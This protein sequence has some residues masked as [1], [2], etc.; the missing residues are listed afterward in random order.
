M[1][2]AMS[3]TD[4]Y[5]HAFESL[6]K[7]FD[8]GAPLWLH[9]TRE[10]AISR[11]RELGFPTTKAE[12]WKYTNVAP[13]TKVP[14]QPVP[15]AEPH[16]VAG[17]AVD[18]YT[19]GVLKCS[20]LVFING[21]FAP[22][23]SY[24]RW[25]PE[26]VRVRSLSEVLEKDARSLE[27]HLGRVAALDGNPFTALNT[28]FMQEGAFIHVPSGRV[29]E[30]PIHLLFVSASRK[31]PAVSY[32]RNLVVLAENSQA[33][34]I[35]SYAGLDRG[36]Y[37]TNA[38]TEVVVGPGAV[39][40][41]YK[42]Q[43]ESESAFH[44]A[45]MAVHQDRSS[46]VACNSISL[47]GALARNDV[48]AIFKGEGGELDLNGLYAVAGQ[49]HVDNHTWIDHARPNCTSRELYKGILD[50]KSRGIFNA[51]IFVRKEGQ[52]TN[53]R[54]TNKNLLLSNDAFVDSTPGLEILADDV[55][56]S[57]GS[58]IGQLDENAIFYLRS[59]GIDEEAARSLL[60]YAFASELINQVKVASMR[61][62]LDQLIL[63]RLPRADTVKEAV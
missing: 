33:T 63:S 52:K 35:E 45:T 14:F 5:V 61:I 42:M 22:R 7:D 1:A 36:L 49:Q 47:G 55:R 6:Q 60:T 23:L 26:G 54:Q 28:A 2:V 8:G 39:L 58:T 19:F 43:R 18:L 27:P 53:A 15:G 12:A 11:F 13:I 37:F 41:H 51:M 30:E 32:P 44:V 59:R 29:V 46:R 40:D 24:L 9:R 10:A 62:K 38:V 50:G 3:P 21:R 16:G 4:L 57:H 25:L 17:E 48:N 20:Q 34:V 31:E 56:C